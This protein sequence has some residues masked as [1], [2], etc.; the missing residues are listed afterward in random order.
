MS[1]LCL[2]VC[3]H[4][5]VLRGSGELLLQGSAAGPRGDGQSHLLFS[6]SPWLSS[7]VLFVSTSVL[8]H[9]TGDLLMRA[10]GRGEGGRLSS[11]TAVHSERENIEQHPALGSGVQGLSMRLAWGL[12]YVSEGFPLP[13]ASLCDQMSGLQAPPRE[14]HSRLPPS[15]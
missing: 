14:F 11:V 8:S 6:G 5:C 7:H 10:G 2:C 12:V 1:V 9:F 3:V 15:I 13:R 4:A